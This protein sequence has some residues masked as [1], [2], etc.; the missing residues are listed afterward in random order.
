LQCLF[1]AAVVLTALCGCR[2]GN[3]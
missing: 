1:H 3:P 2:S